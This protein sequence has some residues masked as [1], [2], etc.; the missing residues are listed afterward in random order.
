M[1]PAPRRGG[2][3]R[4]P[5]RSG[6]SSASVAT[7]YHHISRTKLAFRKVGFEEVHSAH[8]R[9]FEWRDLYSI[10]REF[11]AYYRYAVR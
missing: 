6:R 8:A 1:V 9:I 7:Q 3:R 4:T 10:V 11:A 2:R 5:W